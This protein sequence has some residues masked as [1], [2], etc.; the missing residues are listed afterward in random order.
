MDNVPKIWEIS[1]EYKKIKSCYSLLVPQ[2]IFQW[3]LW[4]ISRCY[5]F[6]RLELS[7]KKE[8]KKNFLKIMKTYCWVAA[9][10]LFPP[11]LCPYSHLQ[12]QPF[13]ANYIHG[14]LNS[15]VTK[16][17][18]LSDLLLSQLARHRLSMKEFGCYSQSQISR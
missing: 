4:Q 8:Q 2:L 6:L 14:Q 11:S 1:A 17:W 13:N 9:L 18:S 10:L 15:E 12:P 3:H 7:V 5:A 16:S